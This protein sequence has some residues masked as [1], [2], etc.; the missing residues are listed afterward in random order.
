MISVIMPA[1]NADSFIKESIHSILNQSYKDFELIIINDG[2]TDKTEQ[3]VNSF[4]DSRIKLVNNDSNM[5]IVFSLNKAISLAQ[6]E[7]IARIDSDD[8]ADKNRFSLQI[9]YLNDNNLDIC[10]SSITTFGLSKKYIPYPDSQED[11]RFFSIFGS[12]VAHPTVFGY[13]HLFKRFLYHN[14]IA[15]DYDLWTRMLCEDIKIGNIPV[16]LLNYRVHDNQLT[17][18]FTEIIESSILISKNFIETYIDDDDIR[19]ELQNYKCF[20]KDSYSI[21]GINSFSKKICM[22]AKKKHVSVAMQCRVISI[23][24]RRS[25]SYNL[26]TLYSYIR[27]IKFISSN[28]LSSIDLKL[29]FLF[30]FSIKKNSKLVDFV[31]FIQKKI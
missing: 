23:M 2:S 12:P 21:T 17:K 27:A 18:D 29:V 15:E 4:E 7:Y 30:I 11:V 5:G 8:I 28:V 10:G 19:I 16:S 13:T 3:I 22:I 1:F 14:M 6:G 20:M 26:Y 31:R 9:D 24:Y 25:S